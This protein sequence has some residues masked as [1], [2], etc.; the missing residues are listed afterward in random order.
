MPV[1][2]P[3]DEATRIAID[4]VWQK[5]KKGKD[6]GSKGKWSKGKDKGK[7]KGWKGPHGD[8]G[9]GKVKGKS[10]ADGGKKRTERE[11]LY[12]LWNARTLWQGLLV[13]GSED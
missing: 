4:A 2:A 7:G 10:K 11:R 1:K 13:Q 12:L 8:G 5:G 3:K 6:G 9:K